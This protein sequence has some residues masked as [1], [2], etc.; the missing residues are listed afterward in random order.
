VRLDHVGVAVEDLR[1][2]AETWCGLLGWTAGPV[3][4]LPEVTV[5]FLAPPGAAGGVRLELLAGPAVARFLERRGPG[6][7]HLAFAVPDVGEALA[8]LRDRGVEAV[9]RVPRPGAEGRP[10]A[11]LHPRSC[12]G[13]LVEL[14]G[15][16]AAAHRRGGG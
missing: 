11:F 6:L 10:V 13:V 16:D 14:V 8:A 15:E 3:R 12:G 7:H 2:A 5:V 9:D 4:A 1:V